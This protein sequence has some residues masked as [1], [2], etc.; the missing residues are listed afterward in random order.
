MR[1]KCRRIS[2][3]RVD[4]GLRISDLKKEEDRDSPVGAA[5]SRDLNNYYDLNGLNDSIDLSG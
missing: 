5:F 3:K 2:E 4:C 1:Y